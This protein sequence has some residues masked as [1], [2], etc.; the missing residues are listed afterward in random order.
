M[1]K[2]VTKI[3]LIY[4]FVFGL[5]FVSEPKAAYACSCA[6]E[7]SIENQLEHKTAIFTG[8]VLSVTEPE[9]KEIMSSADL[10]TVQ[11]EVETVWKGE[12]ESQTKVYTAQSS[13]SCGYE[14]FKV[15]QQFIVF[16]YGEPDHLETGVC[17]GNKTVASAEKE[18]NILGAGYEPMKKA[19]PPDDPLVSA[20]VSKDSA[21]TFEKISIV[22]AVSLLL[23]FV[24]AVI[25]KRS[26][27]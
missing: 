17:E 7:P 9:K 13:V 26:R 23:F 25:Y 19:A 1:W 10:V 20:S 22:T 2:T 21:S 3:L 14:G 6:T 15:D 4:M 24:L 12:V 18:L 16:A 11:F 5:W 8:K 27:R